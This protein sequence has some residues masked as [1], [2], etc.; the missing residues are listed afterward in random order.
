MSL[1]SLAYE[2]QRPC[3][4]LPLRSKAR[5]T[6]ILVGS[7]DATPKPVKTQ[8]TALTEGLGP[9]LQ[10]LPIRDP[11]PLLVPPPA[12]AQL[13]GIQRCS[14]GETGTGMAHPSCT[15]HRFMHFSYLGWSGG[16]AMG[17]ISTSKHLLFHYF[18][19]LTLIF[20]NCEK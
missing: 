2:S 15:L 7:E 11:M 9:T 1:F 12:S 13:L 10:G 4:R 20:L 19:Q 18:Q 5:R 3:P 8:G 17:I 6:P 14:V 16:L